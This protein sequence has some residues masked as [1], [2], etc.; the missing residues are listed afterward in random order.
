MLPEKS[1]RRLRGAIR[2]ALV[3]GV[4]WS[5]LSI[6]MYAILR[7]IGMVSDTMAWLNIIPL[8]VRFG[9]VGTIAGAAFSV[10][11]SV[12]YRG[13]QLSQISWVR[14]GIAAGVVTALFIPVFLQTMNVLSGGGLAPWGDILD[15]VPTTG[16]FGAIAAASS[17]RLAQFA[18]KAFPERQ[19]QFEPSGAMERLIE[20]NLNDPRGS[21]EEWEYS[22]THRTAQY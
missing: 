5:A 2:N 11:I 16:L 19:D 9:V 20:R 12:F 13:R 7:I 17:L 22:T 14:F 8:A 4:C 15:D 18:D 3:W 6:P 10:A 21:A 1:F